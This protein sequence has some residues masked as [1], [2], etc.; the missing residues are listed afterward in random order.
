MSY[1]NIFK[2]RTIFESHKK[3][4]A[5]VLYNIL[6]FWLTDNLAQGEFKTIN[7]NGTMYKLGDVNMDGEI[8]SEDATLIQQYNSD[9][10][11]FSENQMLLGDINS[12]GNPDV[13]DSTRVQRFAINL[14]AYD[15]YFYNTV[16]TNDNIKQLSGYW[17][18][19]SS[20]TGGEDSTAYA[21][22]YIESIQ[23]AYY[24]ENLGI[25]PVI[26]IS[27]SSISK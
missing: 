4:P 25:R 23:N 27:G 5:S 1:S 6:R 19:N 11:Q 20:S 12:S 9:T 15:M 13:S 3:N 7:I 22:S 10:I 26:T 8:T 17:L 21:I 18:L 16:D 24:N 14:L 2:T